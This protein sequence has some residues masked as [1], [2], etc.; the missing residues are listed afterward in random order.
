MYLPLFFFPFSPIC[1]CA[2]TH[3]PPHICVAL[4]MACMKVRGQVPRVSFLLPP[5]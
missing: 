4:S 5:I 1:V 2:H 3:T